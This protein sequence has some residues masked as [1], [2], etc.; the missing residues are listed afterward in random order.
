MDRAESFGAEYVLGHSARELERLITQS[1]HFEPFTAQFFR[2]AGVTTGL[3]VLDVGC[4][5]GDVSLLAAR[6][7]GATGQVVGID[8]SPDA[9]ATASR[10]ARDHDAPNARFVAGEA[11]DLADE[12][13][14]DA[15]VGRFVLMFCPD[16]VAVLL[17]VVARVRP[18]GLIAFQEADWTGCRSSPEIPI[19]SHC[20]R[21]ASETFQR[22]GAD[23]LM[24]LK[25]AATYAAAGLPPPALSLHAGIATGPDHP[26]YTIVAET[27][28]TLL[29]AAEQSGIAT[30][31]EVDVDTLARRISDEVVDARGTAIWFSLIGAA[32]RK[33]EEQ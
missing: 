4:G 9:V 20:A 7:V 21:W 27:I 25:L 10:R 14:F 32:A 11:S 26:L 31:S 1:R 33:P 5:A 29:P 22:S 28:R 17:Q 3:R 30:A 8:R 13:P 12:A 24:G 16:P 23:I 2:E 18:G 19:W 15:A 6:M